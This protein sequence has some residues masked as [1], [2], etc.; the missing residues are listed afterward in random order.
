MP[1]NNLG[2]ESPMGI[3]WNIWYYDISNVQSQH[4]NPGLSESDLASDK[5]KEEIIVYYTSN[6]RHDNI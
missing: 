6:Y 1:M 4:A 2:G 5:M 3:P